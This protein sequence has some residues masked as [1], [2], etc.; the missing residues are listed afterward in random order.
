MSYDRASWR[1]RSSS[2]SRLSRSGR[3]AVARR[4]RAS[5]TPAR[6]IR[7]VLAEGRREV[8][9]V[10]LF[11]AQNLAKI[12][13]NAELR[14]RLAL[15]DARPIVADGDDLVLEVGAQH[16][17]RLVGLHDRERLRRGRAAQVV[18]VL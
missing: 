18:D 3:G 7:D 11:V 6:D 17:L 2:R 16:R 4:A 9:Q 13:G 12:L 14:E 5:S 15:L 1:A 8:G 10:L